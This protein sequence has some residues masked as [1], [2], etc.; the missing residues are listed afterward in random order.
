MRLRILA[1]ALTCLSIA[2]RAEA[3]SF[4][5]GPQLS[6]SRP[7]G[8]AHDAMDPGI[9]VGAMATLMQDSTAGV[10]VD[11]GYHHWPGSAGL[12][13]YF[14]AAL[15]GL[16]FMS[17]GSR[18][19]FSAIEATAHVKVVP[20][21]RGPVG[22]WIQV[23]AGVYVVNRTLVL[24]GQSSHAITE[25]FGYKGGVGVDLRT[26]ANAKLGLDASFHYL[27]SRADLGTNLTVF[28][29]GTHVLFGR[30]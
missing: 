19:T 23:G 27:L 15:N 26:S 3:L 10:G 30:W 5:V 28:T 14:D 25:E 2:A 29:I 11:V 13:R 6:L 16:G 20:P 21:L 18:F 1:L 17:T 8:R 9:N 4:D 12:D 7:T 24:V 22:P